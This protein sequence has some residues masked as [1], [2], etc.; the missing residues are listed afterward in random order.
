MLPNI[1]LNTA[2]VSEEHENHV[3]VCRI[4]LNT[5]SSEESGELENC[6]GCNGSLKYVHREC[7]SMSLKNKLKDKLEG[8]KRSDEECTKSEGS[9]FELDCELC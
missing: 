7:L 9:L 4:C 1:N 5:V 6:C 3:R 2:P 8:L